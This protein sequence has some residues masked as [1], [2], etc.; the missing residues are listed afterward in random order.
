MASGASS[1]IIPTLLSPFVI[2]TSGKLTDS[3]LT[4]LSSA[5]SPGAITSLSDTRKTGSFIW[6]P[7]TPIRCFTFAKF[8]DALKAVQKNE[9]LMSTSRLTKPPFPIS[10]CGQ[11]APGTF[12]L[13]APRAAKPTEVGKFPHL[14]AN[15]YWDLTSNLDRDNLRNHSKTAGHPYLRVDL[16]HDS[17]TA[18]ANT[19]GGSSTS[20][21]THELASRFV[22]DHRSSGAFPPGECGPSVNESIFSVGNLSDYKSRKRLVAATAARLVGGD[23]VV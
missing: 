15:P 6:R 16:S 14:P 10:A 4:V 23:L 22:P 13:N 17:E 19:E 20:T 11:I 12:L 21:G 3:K 5:R 18:N 7:I 9:C 1:V 2:K 8:P